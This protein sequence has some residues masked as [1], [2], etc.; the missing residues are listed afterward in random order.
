MQTGDELT[1][2]TNQSDLYIALCVFDQQCGAVAMQDDGVVLVQEYADG[3]DL[4]SLLTRSVRLSERRTVRLVIAPLLQALLY[5]HSKYIIHRCGV[6]QGLGS[7]AYPQSP[8]F[9]E[10][11]G[12]NEELSG[13][14]SFHATALSCST[15]AT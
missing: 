2:R 15:A 7:D 3:G 14:P 6:G 12:A 4:L 10:L 13:S 11:H 5:L 8:A 1:N 9:A